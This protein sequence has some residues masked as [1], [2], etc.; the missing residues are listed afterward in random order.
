[1]S[2]FSAHL[3]R[4]NEPKNVRVDSELVSQICRAH[5][6]SQCEEFGSENGSTSI[7]API[8]GVKPL[9][10]GTD[11]ADITV[12]AKP[13]RSP[14]PTIIRQSTE[15]SQI[16]QLTNDTITA[17]VIGT[18]IAFT[19]YN[20]IHIKLLRLQKLRGKTLSSEYFFPNLI[21]ERKIKF[22]AIFNPIAV[23]K[24]HTRLFYLNFRM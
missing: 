19:S 7:P 23:T 6:N 1:M 9:K 3:E 20:M 12:T 16:S 4:K 5:L 13:P 21:L 8:L 22:A 11:K 14:R 2:N 18:Q 15:S 10:I 24:I 17:A